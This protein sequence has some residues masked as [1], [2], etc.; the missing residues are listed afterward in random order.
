MKNQTL[1]LVLFVLLTFT[2]SCSNDDSINYDMDLTSDTE[3]TSVTRNFYQN[4]LLYASE[5][6]NIRNQKI[7]DSEYDSGGYTEYKYNL[8]N[9]ISQLSVFKS[10]GQLFSSHTYAY[11]SYGR[12]IEIDRTNSLNS[13]SNIQFIY[14][15]NEIII[16]RTCTDGITSTDKLTLN[17]NKEIMAVNRIS[18]NGIIYDDNRNRT[19]YYENGNL[20]STRKTD[21]NTGDIKNSYFTYTTKK[22]NFHFRKY[23]FGKEWKMNFT[24]DSFTKT[25]NLEILPW[26]SENLVSVSNYHFELANRSSNYQYNEENK[27]DKVTRNYTSSNVKTIFIYEYN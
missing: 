12:I 22:N 2:Y 23:L 6:L 19:Y 9:L 13:T 25:G 1:Y 27:I 11:D 4:N 7:I 15:S 16:S 24:L 17:S 3:L 26:V 14:N 8:E 18:M 21:L 5:K 10:N 20:L